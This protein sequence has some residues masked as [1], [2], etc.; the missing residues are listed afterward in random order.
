[1]LTLFLEKKTKDFSKYLFFLDYF[2][3]NFPVRTDPRMKLLNLFLFV[4]ATSADMAKRS[5]RN[6]EKVLPIEN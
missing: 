4:R 5:K 3:E 1:M 6:Q 2:S